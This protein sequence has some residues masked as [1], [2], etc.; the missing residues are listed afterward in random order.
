VEEVVARRILKVKL[1]LVHQTEDQDS[2][3]IENAD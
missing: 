2:E 3:E 1:H